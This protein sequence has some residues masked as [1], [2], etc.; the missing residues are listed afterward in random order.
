MLDLHRWFASEAA[1]YFRFQTMVL[2]R[3]VQNQWITSNFM[4]NYYLTNPALS[5]KDFDIMDAVSDAKLQSRDGVLESDC[6][7]LNVCPL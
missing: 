5:E 2:R 4:M 1:D 7:L 6:F 3:Y